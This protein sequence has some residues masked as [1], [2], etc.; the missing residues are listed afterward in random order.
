M[1]LQVVDEKQMIS[2][3]TQGACDVTR[4]DEM[5]LNAHE[6]QTAVGGVNTSLLCPVFDAS[7][8]WRHTRIDLPIGG[9]IQ[10]PIVVNQSRPWH[11]HQANEYCGEPA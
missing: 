8:K 5:W 3:A 11:K 6:N 7:C 10:F 1:C 4:L 2:I 9:F